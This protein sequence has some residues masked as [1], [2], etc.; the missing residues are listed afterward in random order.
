MAQIAQKCLDK[1][2]ETGDFMFSEEDKQQLLLLSE[3]A[4]EELKL[5]APKQKQLDKI[6]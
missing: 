3:Q 4:E 6:R 1:G 2:K 5:P